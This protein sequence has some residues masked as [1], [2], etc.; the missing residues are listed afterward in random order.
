MKK[1]KKNQVI[2][3]AIYLYMPMNSFASPLFKHFKV[4]HV[5][6]NLT[7]KHRQIK[8]QNVGTFV[9]VERLK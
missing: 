3:L 2:K 1:K 5:E 6:N 8:M 9:V 7:S 4:K